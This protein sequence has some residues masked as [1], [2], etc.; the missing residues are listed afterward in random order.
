MLA[1]LVLAEVANCKV[2]PH[3]RILART[4]VPHHPKMSQG[5]L[6]GSS[7]D[8]IHLAQRCMAERPL[9]AERLSGLKRFEDQISAV[10]VS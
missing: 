7:F 6:R 5:H 4:G 9:M 10:S 8:K 2:A 3:S 1:T